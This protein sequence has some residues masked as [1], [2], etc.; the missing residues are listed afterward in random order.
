MR[1]VYDFIVEPLGERYDN[2]VKVGDVSLITNTSLES[3]KHVNNYAKVIE[4]PVGISTP[5]R[6]GDTIVVHQNV[7]RTFY[8]MK[9]KKKNS[10]SF[11]KD[12]KFLCA[13]DQVYLYKTADNPWKAL[14]DRCF[15]APIVNTDDY[16]LDKTKPLVGILKISNSSLEEF[17]MSTGDIVGFTPNSE[18]E[19]EVDNQ[20][21]YCMRTKDIVIKYEHKQNQEEYNRSWASG[22]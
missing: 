9:G 19:F 5:I 16:S 18:W 22:C 4:T 21:M 10:R 1:S 11:L 15:V 6:K 13:V 3:W 2:T 12:N 8:D 14:G 17:K 20:L 7:F